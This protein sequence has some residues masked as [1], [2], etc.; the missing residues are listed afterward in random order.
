[1][2][3]A[4][5]EEMLPRGNGIFRATVPKHTA[6]LAQ[7][8]PSLFK[9]PFLCSDTLPGPH[10]PVQF[11]SYCSL[12]TSTLR[13]ERVLAGPQTHTILLTSLLCLLMLLLPLKMPFL[14][15]LPWKIL[16]IL[17]S[18]LKCPLSWE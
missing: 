13:P 6:L 7:E 5:E 18:Q 17:Q 1:M 8:P 9:P 16:L 3:S 15:S 10:W 14:P 2:L 11:I 4:A 12:P